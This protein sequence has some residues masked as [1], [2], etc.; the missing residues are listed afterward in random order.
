VIDACQSGQALESAD[1]R[2][3]PLNTRSLAQL[4]YDKGMYLRAADQSYQAAR[5]PGLLE[6]GLLSY[7]LVV[8]RLLGEKAYR[9]GDVGDVSIR[10]WLD[11]AVSR[12]PALDEEVR[13]GSV[14]SVRGRGTCSNRGRRDQG[15]PPAAAGVLSP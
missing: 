4:A 1:D 6:H 5:E 8:E 3:A 10:E 15:A 14:T 9:N 11:Y 7:A 2:H 13:L 12:V